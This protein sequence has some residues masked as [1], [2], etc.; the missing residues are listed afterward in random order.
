MVGLDGKPC[1]VECKRCTE[2]ECFERIDFKVFSA[3]CGRNFPQ[4]VEVEARMVGQLWK[5]P[6]GLLKQR[7][8]G[9]PQIVVRLG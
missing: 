1:I 5:R 2:Y 7:L 3:N 8:C 4:L 6:S 9:R